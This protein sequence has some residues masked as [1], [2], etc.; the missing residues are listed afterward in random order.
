MEETIKSTPTQETPVS[1]EPT[2]SSKP[3][4]G[5]NKP[6]SQR[7][8]SEFE[9]KTVMTKFVNKT[10]KGGRR[11]RFAALV[12]V[13]NRKGK[14]GYGTGKS[15]E[16]SVAVKKATDDAKK[17]VVNVLINKKGGLYHEFEV[18]QGATKILFKTA[19]QGS[20]IV[21]GGVIRTILELAGYK[22]VCCK[23]M[24]SG[25]PINMAQTTI[26]GLLSQKTPHQIAESRGLSLKQLFKGGHNK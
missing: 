6:R 1:V 4:Y 11:S 14:V 15:K 3:T 22:D 21:A 9:E 7:A 12:I 24:G 2:H 25:S 19:P 10:T 17:N 26:K 20:G 16:I 8:P 18:K 5:A 23:N 13:G